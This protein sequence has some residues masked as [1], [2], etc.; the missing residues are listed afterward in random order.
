MDLELEAESWVVG[1]NLAVVLVEMVIEAMRVDEITQAESVVWK[2]REEACP[3]HPPLPLAH[4][5]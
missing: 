2:R 1:R 4:E 5:R 3:P